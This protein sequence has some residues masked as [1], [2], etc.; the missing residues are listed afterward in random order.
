MCSILFMIAQ[1]VKVKRGVESVE[2]K[3]EGSFYQL[4]G[5]GGRHTPSVDKQLSQDWILRYF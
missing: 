3:T 1:T 2:D 4:I 5:S